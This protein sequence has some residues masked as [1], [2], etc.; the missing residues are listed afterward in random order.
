M[1]P[2]QWK[3][4]EE[5][6]LRAVELPEEDREVFVNNAAGERSWLRDEVLRMLENLPA[7][8]FLE[9]APR[10]EPARDLEGRKLG[11]FVIDEVVGRGGM[12]I[13]YRA[14]QEGLNRVVAVKVLPPLLASHPILA[15]RFRR[16]AYAA[17]KLQHPGIAG[18]L[19]YGTEL[20][21]TYCA[22]EYVDGQSL[23]EVLVRRERLPAEEGS[24]GGPSVTTLRGCASLVGQ[25]CRA[26]DYAHGRGVIHRDVKPSNTLVDSSGRPRLIDFGL[27]LLVD[28]EHITLSGETLGTPA[29]MSPEQASSAGKQIDHR[30]DIYSAGALLYELLTGRPPYTGKSHLEILKRIATEEVRPLRRLNP[31]VPVPLETICLRALTKEPTKRYSTAAEMADDLGATRAGRP[32]ALGARASSSE[33]GASASDGRVSSSP[34]PSSS[35]SPCWASTRTGSRTPP[36]SGA[37]RDS[38]WPRAPAA[39]RG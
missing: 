1:K 35:S 22:M 15:E 21:W 12:G 8:G 16:E 36:G 28:R 26:L 33:R 11:E 19:S 25:I 9:S 37:W 13:V 6:Y 17:S 7:T 24:G 2:E 38:S 32:S 14:V 5:L 39:P 34:R 31:K 29:Y 20:G 23:A 27:A 18:V 3:L 30:T 4:V 10:V